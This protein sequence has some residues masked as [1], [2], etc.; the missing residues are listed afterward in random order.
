MAGAEAGIISLHRSFYVR[1]LLEE[2]QRHA[3]RFIQVEVKANALRFRPGDELPEIGEASF[4]IP[5]QIGLP[6]EWRELLK[7]AL[8]PD[9]VDSCLRQAGEITVRVGIRF[10]F[11]QRISVE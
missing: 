11:Q 10:R 9:A 4:I 6:R 2:A 7:D 5:A 8:E 3:A 1:L